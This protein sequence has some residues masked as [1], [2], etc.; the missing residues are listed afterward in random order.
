MPDDVSIEEIAYKLDQVMNDT[1]SIHVRKE[2]IDQAVNGHFGSADGYKYLLDHASKYNIPI[3][4]KLIVGFADIACTQIYLMYLRDHGL[5]IGKALYDNIIKVLDQCSGHDPRVSFVPWIRMLVEE[6]FVLREDT[7]FTRGI[8]DRAI[9]IVPYDDFIRL[10]NNRQSFKSNFDQVLESIQ[11]PDGKLFDFLYEKCS[12]RQ[13]ESTVPDFWEFNV[14]SLAKL[15]R[16]ESQRDTDLSRIFRAKVNGQC[17]ESMA[18]LGLLKDQ[19]FVN[20]LFKISLRYISYK[21]THPKV[22]EANRQANV[23]IACMKSKLPNVLVDMVLDYL[24]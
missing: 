1:R 11:N 5:M 12:T 16:F 3:D 14:R 21:I 18:M 17:L 19:S 2:I 4:L 13:L 15:M 23:V 10:L 7:E 24:I 20:T 22:T 8:I 6:K 9:P